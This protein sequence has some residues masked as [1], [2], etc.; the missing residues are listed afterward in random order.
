MHSDANP[1]ISSVTN[2]RGHLPGG[3]VD[4]PEASERE[5]F[6]NVYKMVEGALVCLQEWYG[7]LTTDTEEEKTEMEEL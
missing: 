2:W 5:H 6:K 3:K 1:E 4:E 7:V